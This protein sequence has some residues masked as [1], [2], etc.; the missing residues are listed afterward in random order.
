[1]NYNT[2]Q[3]VE[4]FHLLFLAQLSQKVDK[5]LYALKGGC[6]LRFFFNSIRYSEDIDLDVQTIQLQTL[7]NKVDRIL[8]SPSFVKILQ[9][10]EISIA[11]ISQHK[12]TETVQRWKL[13]LNTPATRV[14]LPTKIEFSRRNMGNATEFSAVD[15]NLLATYKMVPVLANH[16]TKNAMWNKKF[17]LWQ[18]VVK[19]RRGIFLICIYC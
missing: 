14:A 19:H 15:R 3:Y 6:N 18:I 5:Q 12:Q 10:Y 11:Q 13:A 8:T 4:I 16:Y 17:L 9:S 7:Q 2:K 1:M